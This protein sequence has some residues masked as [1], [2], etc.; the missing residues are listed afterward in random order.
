MLPKIN[1]KK[2]VLSFV[3]FLLLGFFLLVLV[4][5]L[6]GGVSPLM[7]AKAFKSGYR[8]V[9][10]GN[11][12]DT[13]GRTVL[14]DKSRY[15]VEFFDDLGG[16]GPNI[17]VL[18]WWANDKGLD[19]RI[20]GVGVFKQ[21]EDV[22]ESDDKYIVLNGPKGGGELKL[23]FIVKQGGERFASYQSTFC[24]EDLSLNYNDFVK[25]K[26]QPV[27]VPL[28][29]FNDF[30]EEE[31]DRSLKAGDVVGFI[32]NFSGKMIRSTPIRAEILEDNQGVPVISSL[33]LRRF[34]GESKLNLEKKEIKSE[35]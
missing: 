24:V 6:R 11:Y 21:W 33:V 1:K 20:Y 5:Y 3:V 19:D 31:R 32:L 27:N 22:P 15:T 4:L 16:G 28:G 8:L 12:F 23:R 18:P 26:F 34:G 17:D 25:M 29:Y 2:A 10:Q 7:A 30:S 14:A 9:Y 35:E 13:V